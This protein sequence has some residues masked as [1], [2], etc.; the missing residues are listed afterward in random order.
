ME[1]LNL[2][3]FLYRVKE[4]KNKRFIFDTVRKKFVILTPEEWVRQNF[5]SYLVEYKKYPASLI[6]VEFEF[7]LNT[8][9]KRSDIVLFGKAGQPI[10]VV[11]CKA[12]SVKITQKVF[13]QIARYNMN[14]R[15]DY[16]IV[17]N[18][19][20]HYCCKFDNEKKSF[21]FLK[22]IPEFSQIE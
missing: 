20:E 15:V 14:F 5:I 21:V 18:G 13:D 10:L 3:K 2:P 11:E 19:L 17:T 4:D 12:S 22:D 8:T 16:L 7:K 9:S 6:G 1:E